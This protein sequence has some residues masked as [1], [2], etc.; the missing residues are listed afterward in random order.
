MV[1]LQDTV[2]ADLVRLAAEVAAQSGGLAH[3]FA[4]RTDAEAR[5]ATIAALIA[6][7]KPTEIDARAF[8]HPSLLREDWRAAVR[9]E[10]TDLGYRDWVAAILARGTQDWLRADD[11]RTLMPGDR[12]VVQ[13]HGFVESSDGEGD[14][15]VSPGDILPIQDVTSRGDRVDITL[16]VSEPDDDA[17]QDEITITYDAQDRA[18]LFPLSRIGIDAL[19]PPSPGHRLFDG[20]GEIRGHISVAVLHDD[21]SGLAPGIFRVIDQHGTVRLC[22]RGEGQWILSRDGQRIHTPIRDAYARLTGRI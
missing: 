3:A 9:S 13:L 12:V 15:Q 8:E 6:G 21:Q 5:A 4:D 10:A 18:G 17:D 2:Y 14:A 7:E 1:T 16:V 11:V 20:S 22:G 19:S